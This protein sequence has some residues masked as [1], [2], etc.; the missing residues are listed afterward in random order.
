M[1]KEIADVLLGGVMD[2]A[3]ECRR[4]SLDL[5]KIEAASLYLKA[6]KSV[7]RQC[8]GLALLFFC[9]GIMAAGLVGVPVAIIFLTPWT[10]G[11]KTCALGALGALYIF[12]PIFFVGRFFS[13]KSWMGWTQI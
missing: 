9:L 6:V 11:M 2:L 13:Q 8:L 10:T 12:L 3:K 7:R 1:I 4:N 5:A